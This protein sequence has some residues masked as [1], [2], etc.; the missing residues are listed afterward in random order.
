MTDGI[1]LGT[2]VGRGEIPA[3]AYIKGHAYAADDDKAHPTLW[4]ARTLPDAG[5]T[6]RL[7]YVQRGQPAVVDEKRVEEYEVLL[8]HGTWKSQ[9][10]GNPPTGLLACGRDAPERRFTPP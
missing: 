2:G 4:L 7:G 6:M 3:D 5:G 8:D 10:G 1:S 9:E